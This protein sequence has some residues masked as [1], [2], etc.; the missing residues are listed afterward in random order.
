MR[1]TEMQG[2]AT[3]AGPAAGSAEEDIQRFSHVPTRRSAM[4]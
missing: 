2:E 1:Q 3:G 4:S